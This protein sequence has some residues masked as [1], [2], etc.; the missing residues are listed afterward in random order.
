MQNLIIE[1]ALYTDLPVL[2]VLL[3][4][5]V[6]D[7]DTESELKAQQASLVSLLLQPELGDI[8]VARDEGQIVGMVSVLYN[9]ATD[10]DKAAALLE[11]FVTDPRVSGQ[12]VKFQLIQTAVMHA[13]QR[14][15]AHI[16]LITDAIKRAVALNKSDQD[17]QAVKIA[18]PVPLSQLLND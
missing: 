3:E 9:F 1:S 16:S 4:F 13:K 18:G 15:C 14:G 2:Q 17:A 12:G 10:H 11:N 6:Q 5:L 7:G 8:L